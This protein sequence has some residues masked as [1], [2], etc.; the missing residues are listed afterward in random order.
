MDKKINLIFDFDSTFIQLETIEILAE[1]AL[2]EHKNKNSIIKKISNMTNLAMS[3]QLSF[4]RALSDRISLLDLKEI[5]I[6]ETSDFLLDK[7]SPSFDLNLEFIKKNKSSC[8]IISGG[9]KDIIYPIVHKFG[10]IEKNIFANNFIYN[11]DGT[12]KL[13]NSNPLSKDNGKNLIAK[14]IKG[15]NIIIGDGYTDYEV[16]K[17]GNAMKFIQYVE[18]INRKELNN[19]ADLIAKNFQDI[20]NFLNHA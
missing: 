6:K 5:H 12:I 4:N 15:Y 7:I 16:K 14:N 1:Y 20:I 17:N 10:F 9:F 8:Y 2:K 19:K 11:K 18:N 13:D 3:G